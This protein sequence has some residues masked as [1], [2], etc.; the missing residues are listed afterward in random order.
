MSLVGRTCWYLFD[1]DGFGGGPQRILVVAGEV[2]SD[3]DWELA[4]GR[5]PREDENYWQGCSITDI[6]DG[7][8]TSGRLRPRN[9]KEGGA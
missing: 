4:M 6:T 1:E 2:A 3:A 5:P 8:L 9:E 7:T